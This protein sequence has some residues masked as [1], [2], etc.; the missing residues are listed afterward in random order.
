MGNSWTKVACIAAILFLTISISS[1]NQS[2][3][4]T[5]KLDSDIVSFNQNATMNLNNDSDGDGLSDLRE[6]WW[7]CDPMDEDTNKDGILDGASTDFFSK[8]KT[9]PYKQEDLNEDND[10]D[11]DGLPTGA[12]RY[13]VGTDFKRFSTDGDP[14]GDGQEYF[15]INM[16]KIS[17]ADHPLI[18]AYPD[19]RVRLTQITVKPMKTIESTTGGA[20]QDAW[21]VTLE[22]SDG[23]KSSFE[24]G[25]EEKISLSTTVE[26]SVS[27]NP[28][29]LAS[30]KAS[31][32]ITGEFGAHQTWVDEK[33]H[34]TTNSNSESGWNQEDWSTASSSDTAKAATLGFT[35][36]M[37]NCGTIPAE[38]VNPDVNIK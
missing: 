38:D 1:A 26:A 33:T 5:G 4:S 17:P 11:G 30:A 29:E 7:L 10:V 20:K 36:N 27:L 13:D 16:P 15:N 37:K 9:W 8:N 28:L 32:T 24:Y 25:F 34:T 22:T 2:N 21:S 19:L 12:E 6:S 35:M 23:K 14:Y 31:S 18:A 3:T